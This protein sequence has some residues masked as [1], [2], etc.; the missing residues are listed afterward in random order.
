MEY[1]S[2]LFSSITGNQ[3]VSSA[4]DNMFAV[5]DST[6]L[7]ILVTGLLGAY[8]LGSL[9]GRNSA[10]DF[11]TNFSVLFLGALFANSLF[12][13]LE[14]AGTSEIAQTAIS[15]S[16]GMVVASLIIIGIYGRPKST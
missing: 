9:T 12:S 10:F 4:V 6:M 3:T 14:L 11:V 1:L 5:S 8:I 13:E 16:I 15:A 2:N 7:L